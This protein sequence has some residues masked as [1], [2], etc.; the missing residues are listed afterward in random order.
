MELEQAGG[1]AAMTDLVGSVSRSLAQKG[2]R[3]ALAESCTGG[4]VAAA[5]TDRAGASEFLV[6][7]VVA[8][9]NDAK[10]RILG[11]HRTTLSAHGAVSEA[12]A[13][14][15]VA[16]ALRVGMADAAVAV[17]GVAGPGG[18]TSDKPVGTVWIAA[19][20]RGR[21]VARRFHFDGDRA[22]VRTESVRAALEV[23]WHLLEDA[24]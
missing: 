21:E 15:M 18:G 22:R 19:A 1:D 2:L 11:V 24:E 14:E 8:Y 4:M 23:L 13:R 20:L 6:A 3:L 12:V 5:L 9:A 17:T 10:E 16:G 7:G